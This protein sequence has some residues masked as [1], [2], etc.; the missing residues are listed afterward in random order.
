MSIRAPTLL[1]ILDLPLPQVSQE[2]KITKQCYSYYLFLS[3]KLFLNVN[4][5]AHQ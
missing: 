4:L 5:P 2:D 3:L 1:D